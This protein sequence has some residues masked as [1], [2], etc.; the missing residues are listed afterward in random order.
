MSHSRLS[1][2]HHLF[3]DFLCLSGYARDHRQIVEL[4]CSAAL[5]PLY[6]PD[7]VLRSHLV[8][9][10]G[11]SRDEQEPLVIVVVVCGG[12]KSSAALMERYRLNE[13]SM[14]NLVDEQKIL[15][16]GALVQ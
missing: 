6:F 5:A 10:M 15:L 14:P 13:E 7:K 9:R 4:A 11:E 2:I 3:A 1:R 12:N 16:D 8:S